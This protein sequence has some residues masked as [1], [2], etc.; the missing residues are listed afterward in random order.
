MIFKTFYLESQLPPVLSQKFRYYDVLVGRIVVQN[1]WGSS[2]FFKRIF[3]NKTRYTRI[4][5][6]KCRSRWDM[7]IRR[8]KPSRLL[9]RFCISEKC[10]IRW[11]VDKS[12]EIIY[13]EK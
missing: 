3:E 6:V 5:I 1:Y 2:V 4:F 8:S 12:R 13:R 7:R 10:S 9:S 11:K